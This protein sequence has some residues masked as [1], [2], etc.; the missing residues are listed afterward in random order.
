MIHQCLLMQMGKILELKLETMCMR[1]KPSAV[2]V[3]SG[4]LGLHRN[5]PLCYSGA[6]LAL[7]SAAESRLQLTT[8]LTAKER[9]LL[10]PVSQN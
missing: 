8:K 10:R 5:H 6:L 7:Y 4:L 1:L 9:A 2:F 3:R